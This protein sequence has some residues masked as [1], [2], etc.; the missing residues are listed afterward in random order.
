MPTSL[1]TGSAGFVAG[2]LTK[3]LIGQGHTVSG[4]D[5]ANGDDVRDY[6]AIRTAV[7]VTQPDY[8]FHLAAQAY[9]PE[10]TT[11]PHRAIDVNVV[12]TL[13]LLEAIRQTGSN[14][15]VL[16][17]GTSE[18]Y[19]YTSHGIL[20]EDSLCEP[21]TP[22]GVS[23]LAA[24]QLGLVYHR[25]YGIPIVV[26]RAFNH[27]GPKHPPV[28][29]IPSFARR[30]AQVEAGHVAA[31]R[32]GNLEAVRNYLDVRDVIEAYQLAIEQPS[33]IYNVCGDRTVSMR[34][35]LDTLVDL[36][37]CPIP[38]EIDNSLYRAGSSHFPM[39]TAGKLAGAGWKPQ[40]PLE[41][42]LA[43]VLDY[44]RGQM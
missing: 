29:A 17:A 35:V 4:F 26:T 8:V 5:L 1:I 34:W 40:I 12:G 9:V 25:M 2:Y 6:E 23:K 24:G 31:V 21:T 18:E 36:A 38:T 22:Y 42:T 11:N 7:E 32:H 14:A 19:G 27:T 10:G 15:R 28:Y 33:G 43:D 41:Q 20:T 39:P 44:W 30:V 13:N 16:L 3:H 37:N